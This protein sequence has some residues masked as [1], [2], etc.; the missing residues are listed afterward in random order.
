M[1]ILSLVLAQE[2]Y[3]NYNMYIQ[4]ISIYN[5]IL[6]VKHSKGTGHLYLT[7]N[8]HNFTYNNAYLYNITIYICVFKA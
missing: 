8:V 3:V 6:D 2:T 7:S 5:F 4:I 1:A